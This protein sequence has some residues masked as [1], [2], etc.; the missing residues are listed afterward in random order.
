MM[1]EKRKSKSFIVLL[2]FLILL[3]IF[4]VVRTVWGVTYLFKYL[5][6]DN[7][8]WGEIIYI[9]DYSLPNRPYPD[10][11]NI[12]MSLDEPVNGNYRY[13]ITFSRC[14]ARDDNIDFK[15][16]R[17]LAVYNSFEHSDGDII[18]KWDIIISYV[19]AAV[20]LVYLIAGIIIF[21]RIN[22]KADS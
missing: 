7:H 13:S 19:S 14:H 16:E 11:I 10:T 3:F 8:S 22:K 20:F 21:T 9:S 12:L 1:N 4:A 18:T 17:A 15:G 5:T 2:G 6:Y